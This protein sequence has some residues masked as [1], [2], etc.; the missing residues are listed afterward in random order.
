[1]IENK[2]IRLA[3]VD[4][5]TYRT[6]VPVLY[7]DHQEAWDRLAGGELA[8]KSRL[9]GKLPLDAEGYLRLGAADD[10][11]AVHVGA[12]TQQQ[13]LIDAVVNETWIDTIGMTPGNALLIRTG[14]AAARRGPRSSRRSSA[15]PPRSPPS[16]RPPASASSPARP[17]SP[18]SPARSPTPWASTATPC[19]AAAGSPP[20]RRGSASHI[21]TE[22]VPILGTVTCNT[23]LFPQLKAAL[24]EIIDRGLA[25]EIHPDEYAGC[26]YPR[27]I[28]GSSTLSNHAFGLAL[29]LNVPGNGRGTV[30]EMDRGVV[31]SSRTGASA[32]A[33]TGTTPTPCTS[34]WPSWSPPAAQRPHRLT[35]S[36]RWLRTSRPRWF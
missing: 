6:F 16:T 1:M 28:A 3:A 20:T 4:P 29:D 36:L 32:G 9:K 14:S 13:P 7:A 5:A 11:P 18:S 25:D 33:A 35:S 22:A 21:S 19:S 27:F 26:Y 10:A 12:Y 31:D 30:G 24:H 2:A 23:L 34:R 15:T 17:R 8:L